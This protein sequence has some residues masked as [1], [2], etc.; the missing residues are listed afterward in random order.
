M[1][2][3]KNSHSTPFS[4]T[5]FRKR[6]EENFKYWQNFDRRRRRK[7]QKRTNFFQQ[8]V[9]IHT[10]SEGVDNSRA[11]NECVFVCVCFEKERKC[12]LISFSA[13]PFVLVVSR[14]CAI[15]E[16]FLATAAMCDQKY[17]KKELGSRVRWTTD[18]E[19]VVN[20][21]CL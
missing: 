2:S 7:L 20:S 16:G 3:T 17:I 21:S 14:E 19:N 1:I 6:T 12:L 13:F 10:F 11:F 18:N 4:P 5:I 9:P 8:Q 15:R